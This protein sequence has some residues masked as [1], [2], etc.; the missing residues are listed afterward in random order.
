MVTMGTV[1]IK[2]DQMKTLTDTLE[3]V[4]EIWS[5]PGDYPSNAESGPLPSYQYLEGVDGEIRLELNPDELQELEEAKEAGELKEWVNQLDI[6]LPNGILSATW[7]VELVMPNIV[8][9]TVA[10]F[11]PDPDYQVGDDEPDYE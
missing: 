11:E 9:L 2:R 7:E 4:T 10:D 5:D 6:S 8:V 3:V 1:H